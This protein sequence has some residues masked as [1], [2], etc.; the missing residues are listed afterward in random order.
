[1]KE[2]NVDLL[3]NETE[4]TDNSIEVS[5]NDL[6]DH[7][8]QNEIFSYLSSNDLFFNGRTVSTNWNEMVKNIWST[9]IK[10]EMI[11]QVKSIDFIY[12]KEVF[13]KTYEFKLNYLI[14]YKNLLTAYNNNANILTIIY[15]LIPHI[16]DNEIRNLL[17]LFFEF[18]NLQFALEYIQENQ[19][20]TLKNY[21]INEDNFIFFKIKILE[22]M[23]I[24]DNLKD[25]NYLNETKAKFSLLNKDYLENISDFAKLIYSF[26]QGMIEYQILKVEVKDLKEKIENLLKKLQE[27][28]KI[29]P[30][31]KKFLE[32]AYKL[33]IFN[34][35]STPKIKKIIEKFEQCKIRHPLIDFNDECIRSILELRKNLLNNP[36]LIRQ[37]NENNIGENSD[38]NSIDHPIDEK[39]FENICSRRILLT[40]KL[41]IVERFAEIY[42][43][44]LDKENDNLFIVKGNKL[45]LKEF[46]WCMKISANSQEENIT[47]DSLM[48]TKNYLDKNFDYENHIIYTIPRRM[49]KDNIEFDRK[50]KD[51]SEIKNDKE[52]SN[53]ENKNADENELDNINDEESK[54]K[55]SL[56]YELEKYDFLLRL[57]NNYVSQKEKNENSNNQKDKECQEIYC[58]NCLNKNKISHNSKTNLKNNFSNLNENENNLSGFKIGSMPFIPIRKCHDG[59]YEDKVK[60]FDN[61]NINQKNLSHVQ[62]IEDDEEDNELSENHKRLINKLIEQG[63]LA[64]EIQDESNNNI[65]EDNQFAKKNSYCNH[66]NNRNNRDN[67][68]IDFND[69]K[70]NFNYRDPELEEDVENAEAYVEQLC[71]NNKE[72]QNQELLTVLESKEAEVNKLRI[73]KEKLILRKQKTEQILDMMKKFI[74]LKDNMMKNKKYYK[75]ISY[76]LQRVRS[77]ENGN[78]DLV[79]LSQIINSQELYDIINDDNFENIFDMNTENAEEIENFQQLDSLIKEIEM[80]LLEQVNE[81]F[82]ENP[83]YNQSNND[84]NNNLDDEENC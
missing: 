38:G 48:R 39:I 30:K 14:N 79:N 24:E 70:S 52:N 53:L 5:F 76:L 19:I 15:N 67:N 64:E 33:I 80:S 20:D 26:L 7:I 27:T 75:A 81:I 44:C 37:T 57:S 54:T 77:N 41:W 82:G 9:K 78:S 43:K 58:N 47:E 83:N 71:I 3:K 50:L 49:Q 21:L 61:E 56:N 2:K 69:E 10:E 28:S 16:E 62:V 46:L 34:K 60:T 40:K 66:R 55:T 73:E 1:M 25:I 36:S 13:T 35:N 6:P 8:V 23:I 11:D 18:I 32:K 22:L 72:N 65:N 29:W 42:E 59:S 45:T 68:L 4:K 63:I 74:L 51:E 12:E 17:L 84:S 31:K